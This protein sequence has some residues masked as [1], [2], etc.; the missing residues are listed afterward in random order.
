MLAKSGASN[1][2]TA[3]F[4]LA[5]T[6]PFASLQPASGAKLEYAMGTIRDG[7]I[8]TYVVTD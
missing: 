2:C 4:A 5:P 8:Y 7:Q 1:I 3:D 6:C